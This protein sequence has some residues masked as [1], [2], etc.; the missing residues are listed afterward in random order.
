MY[1]FGHIVGSATLCK[2]GFVAH[3]HPLSSFWHNLQKGFAK[4]SFGILQA[5][6]TEGT[7]IPVGFGLVISEGDKLCDGMRT[8][9]HD[10]GRLTP[11]GGKKPVVQKQQSI[12][13]A[14]C[15]LLYDDGFGMLTSGCHCSVKLGFI[16]NVGGNAPA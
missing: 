13:M 16:G 15:K 9:T 3:H 14:I 12:I 11:D 1:L 4:D 2:V 10:K 6:I 7:S 8:V 5:N